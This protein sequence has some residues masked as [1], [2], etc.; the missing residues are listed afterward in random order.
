MS[1]DQSSDETG[2]EASVH[3]RVE[4]ALRDERKLLASVLQ[5]LPLGVGVY[6]GEGN[7]THCNQTLRD[8]ARLDRLPSRQLTEVRR[9]RGYDA[10]G[11]IIAPGDYPGARALRGES[12][13]PG[14][15]FLH[16][17]GNGRERWLRVSAV[18]FRRES[19]E[20]NEAIVV[21]QDIDDLK[22]V[23][24]QIEAAL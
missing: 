22:R 20:G 5:N 10:D 2:H 23:S 17:S 14:L 16:D 8:Y 7:L 12:V 24:E 21:V 15:D 4:R 3:D 6:D 1:E 9:W 19:A 18:P 11:Q 13:M